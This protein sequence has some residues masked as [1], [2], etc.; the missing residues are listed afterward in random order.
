VEHGQYQAVH[1]RAGD[2]QG[3]RNRSA[4]REERRC[5]HRQKQVLDHVHHQEVFGI[6]VHGRDQRDQDGGEAAE[7][8]DHPP[9]RDGYPRTG[10][11]HV[12]DGNQVPA[13]GDERRD[14][15]QRIRGPRAERAER[16]WPRRDDLVGQDIPGRHRHQSDQAKGGHGKVEDRAHEDAW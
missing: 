7:P 6:H 9:A 3:K 16:G 2:P 10:P 5:D 1:T 11:V 12:P 14:P 8:C 13:A 15:W 4:Q